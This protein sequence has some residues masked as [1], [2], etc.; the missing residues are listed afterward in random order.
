MKIP[1]EDALNLFFYFLET[2]KAIPR[3]RA[4]WSHFTRQKHTGIYGLAG[5]SSELQQAN[6]AAKAC[7]DTLFW[8]AIWRHY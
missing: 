8:G 6:T 1:S 5:E 3:Q 7:C 4:N 2:A